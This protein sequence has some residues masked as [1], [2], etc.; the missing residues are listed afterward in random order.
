MPNIYVKQPIK[1]GANALDEVSFRK[2]L[3]QTV[4]VE[5]QRKIELRAQ[6]ILEKETE[7]FGDFEREDKQKRMESELHT[8]MYGAD[9][10]LYKFDKIHDTEVTQAEVRNNV[11][12]SDAM[13]GGDLDAVWDR[14]CY[15][16]VE[17]LTTL[18]KKLKKMGK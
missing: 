17:K 15:G 13:A 7:L 14:D 3:N 16:Y 5:A 12:K 9:A 2:A 11:L 6:K 4:D 18:K 10:K 8:M 1:F